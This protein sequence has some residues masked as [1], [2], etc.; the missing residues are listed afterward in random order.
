MCAVICYHA[1]FIGTPDF[2]NENQASLLDCLSHIMGSGR[3][4][5]LV[6]M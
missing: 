5:G 2:R 3:G 4:G 6:G 1:S